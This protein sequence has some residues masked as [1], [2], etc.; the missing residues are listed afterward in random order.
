MCSRGAGKVFHSPVELISAPCG[1]RRDDERRNTHLPEDPTDPEQSAQ[2]PSFI[3]G[4]YHTLVPSA[5]LRLDGLKLKEPSR[6]PDLMG[7]GDMGES[8]NTY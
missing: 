3:V 1:R 5:L 8:Y 4:H 2:S 6:I 7:S